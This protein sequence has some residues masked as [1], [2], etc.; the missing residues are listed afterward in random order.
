MPSHRTHVRPTWLVEAR[1]S[2]LDQASN[3]DALDLVEAALVAAAAAHLYARL[4]YTIGNSV[5]GAAGSGSSAAP[6]TAQSSRW[7]GP[8]DPFQR[9]SLALPPSPT[10]SFSVGKKV[11]LLLERNVVIEVEGCGATGRA[12][13]NS[14]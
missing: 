6:I 13:T 12:F 1:L 10:A 3:Q 4:C 5:S 2:H 11:Y 8:P 14:R 7:H 9:A